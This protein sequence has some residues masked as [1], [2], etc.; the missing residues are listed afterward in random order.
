MHRMPFALALFLV[1]G[2]PATLHAQTLGDGLWFGSMS[3]PEMPAPFRISYDVS[4]D[5]DV[6][7]V[8]MH[9]AENDAALHDVRFKDGKLVFWFDAGSTRVDCVLAP[10]GPET[11]AG[12]CQDA[13]G[14]SGQLMI[15]RDEKRVEGLPTP[16]EMRDR[17]QDGAGEDE[18]E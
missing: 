9:V 12:D 6:L 13:D 16:E 8:V 18:I 15:T 17:L 5:N 4:L 14:E 10:D 7:T 3:P 1:A 2:V 11:Y